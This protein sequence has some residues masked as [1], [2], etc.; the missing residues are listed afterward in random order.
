MKVV[1]LCPIRYGDP[2]R[3]KL[4][5]FCRPIWEQGFPEWPI[6]EGVHSEDEGPFNRSKGINRAA[7]AAGDWDV[8]LIIDNDCV[9]DPR[10]IRSAVDV[11]RS[12][13]RL[14]VAHDRRVMLNEAG[15]K[16]I[17][18][19]YSGDW[20]QARFVERVWSD[21]VSCAVAVS[22]ST[23]D[24]AGGFD[25]RFVGWGHEDSGFHLACETVS[26]NILRVEGNTFHLWHPVSPDAAQ[27]SPLRIANE[28]RHQQY[29]D[30]R[31]NR[32]AI[33]ALT[34]TPVWDP[35]KPSRTKLQ[36]MPKLL[37]RTVPAERSPE[38]D[39]YWKLFAELNPTWELRSWEEPLNPN[40]FPLTSPL[41]G[42][43]SSGAQKAGLIR[44]ELLWAHGGLY[45]DSDCQPLK[46]LDALL[47]FQ[48]VAGWEDA[49]CV[50][51]AVIGSAKAH[52]VVAELLNLAAERLLAGAG[53]WET[54][55]GVTTTILPHRPDVTLLPP[56]SFYPFHYLEMARAG[57]DF[58]T[59]APWAFVAHMWAHSWGTPK[60]KAVLARRQRR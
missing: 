49:N 39:Q 11:A 4:W 25:E 2:A 56:G 16:R 3:D 36:P 60:Q 44:L 34:A 42:L 29:K 48:L 30:A 45:V 15:T 22:R 1:I 59:T 8:A 54:G 5:A 41:W 55:P 17:L 47:A 9:S 33:Q 27:N 40:D 24:A 23:W 14:V 51:D 53:A 50:P 20:T 43:C 6:F 38:V 12:T 13:G 46:P 10:G 19:G 26:G 32:E 58:A 35:V 37:H 21:S 18:S 7:A 52:P 57:E 28:Q 31:W